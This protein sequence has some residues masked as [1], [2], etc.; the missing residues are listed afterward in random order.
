MIQLLL[1]SKIIVVFFIFTTISSCDPKGSKSTETEDV[2]FEP[3]VVELEDM[4][5]TSAEIVLIDSIS[6]GKAVKLLAKDAIATIELTLPGGEYAAGVVFIGF[7]L[8]SDGFYLIANNKARRTFT[9]RHNQ[10][11]YGNRFI[12]FKSDGISPVVLSVASGSEG[13]EAP[14]WGMLIDK[15]EI[16]DYCSS[17]EVLER[18]TK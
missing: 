2:V 3:M 8:D 12:T 10:W 5:L 1:F 17:A 7:D 4:E 16:V 18:W 6:G 14:E 11:G 9:H 15:I 13:E